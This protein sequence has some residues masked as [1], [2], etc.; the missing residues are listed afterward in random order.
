MT[1]GRLT[2]HLRVWPDS[3]NQAKT[4]NNAFGFDMHSGSFRTP[5]GGSFYTVVNAIIC[6][7]TIHNTR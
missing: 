5:R 2:E 3:E 4:G 1:A 7:A 6:E